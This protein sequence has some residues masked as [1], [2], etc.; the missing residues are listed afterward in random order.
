MH[1]LFLLPTQQQQQ[2][3]QQQHCLRLCRYNICFQNY[4]YSSLK[5]C[6]NYKGIISVR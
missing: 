2:Q 3:R 4:F 5:T 6:S 1:N